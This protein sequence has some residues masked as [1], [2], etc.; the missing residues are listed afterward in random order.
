[1]WA[2]VFCEEKSLRRQLLT[3]LTAGEGLATMTVTAGAADWRL[4]LLGLVGSL[5]AN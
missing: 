1:M 4:L 5:N 2:I 3:V